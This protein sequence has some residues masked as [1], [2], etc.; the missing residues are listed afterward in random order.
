MCCR[1]R[2][3]LP[4][5]DPVVPS[6]L[7]KAEVSKRLKWGPPCL[8]TDAAAQPRERQAP[9]LG[10]PT[11]QGNAL[12]EDCQ[13]VW[14]CTPPFCH[15]PSCWLHKCP[16]EPSPTAPLPTDSSCF[17]AACTALA[18]ARAAGLFPVEEAA[19][20]QQKAAPLTSFYFAH[21]ALIRLLMSRCPS[22]L[23]GTMAPECSDLRTHGTCGCL[24]PGIVR[25]SQGK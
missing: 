18:R 3:G 9:R 12:K 1:G 13:G 20:S 25:K 2:S 6:L 21:A 15:S 23:S 22:P 14:S 17:L 19:F 11:A 8:A 16:R 10:L 5:G 24:M 4:A 7:Y